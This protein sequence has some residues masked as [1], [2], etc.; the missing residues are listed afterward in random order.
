MSF[1][2][3]GLESLAQCRESRHSGRFSK[4]LKDSRWPYW[5]DVLYHWQRTET[6]PNFVARLS[7]EIEDLVVSGRTR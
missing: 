4:S 1:G 7:E 6:R 3:Q 5:V 2:R